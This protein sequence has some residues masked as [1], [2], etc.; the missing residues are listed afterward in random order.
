MTLAEV[1]RKIND[2]SKET[3]MS[4]KDIVDMFDKINDVFAANGYEGTIHTE[5]VGKTR[6][7]VLSVFEKTLKSEHLEKV[8]EGQ[9]DSPI[10]PTPEPSVNEWTTKEVELGNG[11]KAPVVDVIAEDDYYSNDQE[12][13]DLIKSWLD[14]E[15]ENTLTKT[16]EIPEVV[17]EINEKMVEVS[18]DIEQSINIG[19]LLQEET[20]KIEGNYKKSLAEFEKIQKDFKKLQEYAKNNSPEEERTVAKTMANCIRMH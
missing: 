2:Y 15:F 1:F 9:T 20:L 16:N 8:H 4:G 17:K 12:A 3:G 14:P 6:H 10:D 18:D 5:A 19:N 7:S 11:E 13:L